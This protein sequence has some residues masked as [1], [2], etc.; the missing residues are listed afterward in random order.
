MSKSKV[1]ITYR[2]LGFKSYNDYL[3]SDR[4]QEFRRLFFSEDR[5]VADMVRK[6]GFPVC[7]FCR[8]GKRKLVLHHRTYK[9]LGDERFDDV[10]LLCDACHGEVHKV[11]GWSLAKDTRKV[12]KRVRVRVRLTEG[13]K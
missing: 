6:Y 4:W 9:R 3:T 10:S 2:D 13:S 11:K 1:P 5:R 8:K 12:K 7:Q